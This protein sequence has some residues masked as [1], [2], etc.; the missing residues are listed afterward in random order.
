MAPRSQAAVTEMA[1]VL[2]PG[3]RISLIDTDWGTLGLDIGADDLGDAVRRT[4]S[5]ERARPSRGGRRLPDLAR[6]AG[7]RE[8]V[9]T[10]ATQVWSRWDPD[11]SPSPDGCFTMRKLAQDLIDAGELHAGERHR[12]VNTAQDAE[13]NGRFKMSLTMYAV[14]AVRA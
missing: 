9:S 8:I 1:R 2:R 10:Q 13:R 6:T 14:A 7:F 3:G 4:M 5:T 12:F 11:S